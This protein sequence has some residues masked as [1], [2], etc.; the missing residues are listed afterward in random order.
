MGKYHDLYLKTD[1]L[2]LSNVFEAFRSTCLKHHGLDLAHFYTFPGLAWEAC[3][4]KTGVELKPLTDPDMLLLMFERGIVQAIHCYA[5]A[6]NKYVGDKFHPKEV[7][8]Y[9]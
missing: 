5:E 2:L 3:L 1:I 6:N 9:L 7:H 4:K 8:N